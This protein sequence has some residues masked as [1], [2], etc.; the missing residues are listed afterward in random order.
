MRESNVDK[1]INSMQLKIDIMEAEIKDL[2]KHDKIAIE[3]AK[4][5]IQGLM[6]ALRLFKI[7]NNR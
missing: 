2:G 5:Y 1:F 3:L 6:T 7:I 4:Q